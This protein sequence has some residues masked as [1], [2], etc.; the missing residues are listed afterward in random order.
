MK[1]L[2]NENFKAQEK[3]VEDSRKQN[4]LQGHGLVGLILWKWISSKINL[5][6]NIIPTKIPT[7]FCI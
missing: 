1:D 6:I 3:E 5:Y 4:G 2:Y 7:Q